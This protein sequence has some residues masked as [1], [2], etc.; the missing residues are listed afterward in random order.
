MKT[1]FQ[2]VLVL[3]T[4][5]GVASGCS[6]PTQPTTLGDGPYPPPP[7]AP[8]TPVVPVNTGSAA[9]AGRDE[10]VPLPANSST[11]RGWSPKNVRSHSWKKISGPDSY[12]IES[13]NSRETKL[14]NLERGTYEFEWAVTTESGL[15][16]NDTVMVVV[17]DP[18][19]PSAREFI[20]RNLKDSC[21]NCDPNFMDRFSFAIENFHDYVPADAAITVSLRIAGSTSWVEVSETGGEYYIY[22]IND[23]R[24]VLEIDADYLDDPFSA[25]D[26][27]ITF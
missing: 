16:G 8:A 24:F 25:V 17:Y 2:G 13:P 12:F 10:W 14:T 5:T 21:W 22:R 4:L 6:E 26:V 9:N 23:N 11:L 15:V 7:A 20:F 27:K 18:R 1:A 19:T 3:A